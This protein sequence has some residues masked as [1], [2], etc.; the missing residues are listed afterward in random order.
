[1]LIITV[2]KQLGSLGTEIT[3]GITETLHYRFIDKGSMGQALIDYGF[4][5]PKANEYN[6]KAPTFW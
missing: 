1:M 4:T 3:R 5:L 2:S 6:E